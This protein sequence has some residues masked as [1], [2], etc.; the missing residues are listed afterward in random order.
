MSAN[1]A[2]GDQAGTKLGKYE[3]RG[4]LGRG[5]DGVVHRGHDPFVDRDVAIKLFHPPPPAW[6]EQRP[7]DHQGA[8]FAEARAA[9]KLQHPY[10]VMLYDA[11]V[12]DGRNFLVMEYVEGETLKKYCEHSAARL[13]PQ[14]IAKIMLKCCLALEYTHGRGVL[15]R[16]IKPGNIM[17]KRDGAPKLMDFSIAALRHRLE[18]TQKVIVGSPRYMSP[19][20]VRGKKLEPSSDLYS[21][22]M[23]MYHL[24]AGETPFQPRTTAELFDQIKNRPAPDIREARPDVP[25]KLANVVA[26]LLRK[27]PKERH[28]SGK[29]L[30]HDLAP[31]C[32]AKAEGRR[33]ALDLNH[34]SLKKLEF[35]KAFKSRELGELLDASMTVMFQPG[36]VVINEGETDNALYILVMGVAEV[37]KDGHLIAVLEKGDC[38]GEIGFLYAV[39]R[40]ATV[41]AQ[42]HVLL[43]KVNAALLEQMSEE[44]Q[45]RYYKIFSE[46]LIVRLSHT[47]EKAARLLEHAG[48]TLDFVLT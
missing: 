5:T 8:F 46:N 22:G 32:G 7:K 9:G 36:D 26:R 14:R 23:V 6:E 31:L 25:E 39:K 21:L 11:G 40:T 12:A 48:A 30:A 2:A 10:V 42:T 37:R 1:G 16:D 45:L 13:P 3:L 41:I 18:S 28:Q 4:E 38:F 29:E 44:C 15:H 47:T 20:Q 33:R 27:D 24:L 19:E 17:L 34:D 43:L 35:F